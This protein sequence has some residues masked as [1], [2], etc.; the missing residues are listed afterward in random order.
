[1]RQRRAGLMPMSTGCRQSIL[2]S[3]SDA[4]ARCP[5]SVGKQTGLGVYWRDEP[6]KQMTIAPASKPGVPFPEDS[7]CSCCAA[8]HGML[9]ADTISLGA[10]GGNRLS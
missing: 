2:T 8:N 5:A 7:R 3:T 10:F 4:A 1:M 6:E 9:P